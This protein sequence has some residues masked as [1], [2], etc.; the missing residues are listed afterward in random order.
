M[1]GLLIAIFVK[2]YMK[3]HTNVWLQ[4]KANKLLE[5][6]KGRKMQRNTVFAVQSKT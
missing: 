4:L 2:N 1:V 6:I 3:H 5:F